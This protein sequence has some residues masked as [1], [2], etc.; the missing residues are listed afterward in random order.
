LSIL[1]DISETLAGVVSGSREAVGKD[2]SAFTS[3]LRC[4]PRLSAVVVE[5][6][7]RVS[8]AEHVAPTINLD[9]V[10]RL[11]ER[12]AG[13]RGLLWRLS[14]RRYPKLAYRL[15]PGLHHSGGESDETMAGKYCQAETRYKLERKIESICHLP[16]GSIVIHCPRRETSMKIAEVLVVGSNLNKVAKLRDVTEVSPDPEAL[17][18]YQ[19]EIRAIENMYKSIW[20]FHVYLD[21]AKFD[22]QPVVDMALHEELGFPNDALFLDELANE[23]ETVYAILASKDVRGEIP[24]NHLSE[25]IERIDGEVVKFRHGEDTANM[26]AWVLALIHEV[27]AKVSGPSTGAQL[28]IPGS[29]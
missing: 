24:P 21:Y 3:D 2:W 6:L 28:D 22:R 18:P 13:A 23:P 25:V 27:T 10:K 4:S 1:K 8:E 19:D 26:K 5:C 11:R 20:Q 16:V 7:E 12:V 15:R 14:A 17:R 9:D 29:E